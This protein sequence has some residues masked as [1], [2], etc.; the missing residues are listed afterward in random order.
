MSTFSVN[1][2]LGS[3]TNSMVKS[4]LRL[5]K[6]S[7]MAVTPPLVPAPISLKSLMKGISVMSTPLMAEM[8]QPSPTLWPSAWPPASMPFTMAPL[9]SGRCEMMPKPGDA[10][11]G[12]LKVKGPCFFW[13][14]PLG[15]IISFAPTISGAMISVVPTQLLAMELATVLATPKSIS[16]TGVVSVSSEPQTRMFSAFKSRWTTCLL[17]MYFRPSTV[18]LSTLLA[19]GSVRYWRPSLM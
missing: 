18:C 5:P 6:I 12:D 3:S 7:A 13:D 11:C 2:R 16:L 8:A 4:P 1:S 15:V 19:T 17:W 9:P 10:T 14:S